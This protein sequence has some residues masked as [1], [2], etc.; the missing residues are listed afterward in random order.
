MDAALVVEL[1]QVGQAVHLDAMLHMGVPAH[2]AFHVTHVK[3]LQL[4]EEDRGRRVWGWRS[5]WSDYNILLTFS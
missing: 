1:A 2:Q 5:W 3:L 4:G